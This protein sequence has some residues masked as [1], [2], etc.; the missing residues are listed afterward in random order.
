LN[1]QNSYEDS[2]PLPIGD[3]LLGLVQAATCHF[4][5][6]FCGNPGN[7]ATNRKEGGKFKRE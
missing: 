4:S 6:E 2:S 3:K 5:K 7:V 1:L